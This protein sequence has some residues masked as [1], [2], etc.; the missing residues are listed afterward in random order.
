MVLHGQ[1]QAKRQV[2]R[3]SKAFVVWDMP[4]VLAPVSK[5]DLGIDWPVSSQIN[6]AE[7]GWQY[8]PRC[9]EA[10]VQFGSQMHGFKPC[11]AVKNR[12]EPKMGL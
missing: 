1:W 7:P 11:V 6:L 12:G 10:G 5:L 9:V 4:K 2:C 8:G 3:W